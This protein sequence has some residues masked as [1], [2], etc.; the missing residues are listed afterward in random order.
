[1]SGHQSTSIALLDA[2]HNGVVLSSIAHRDT[3]RLY[4][5]QVHGGPRRAS[6]SR[7]RRTRRSGSRSPA[8]VGSV[9]ARSALMRVALPRAAGT[10][11]HEAL[12][13]RRR[14]TLERRAAADRC[15]TSCCAVQERRGRARA[16]ADRER[17]R[18]RASTPTLDALAFEARDVAIVGEVVHPVY[19]LPDR[20]RPRARARRRS[21]RCSRTRRR[22]ASARASCA[23][24][25]RARR[26]CRPPRPPTRSAH[27]AER[28]RD[29]A[30]RAAIGTPAGRAAAT[31]RV[32]LAE[33]VED[34]RRQRDALRLARPRGAGRAG[35]AGGGPAKT[36]LVFWGAGSSSPGLARALPGRVRRSRGV[37]LTRIESRPRARGLGDVHVLPR[38]R[39]ARW[40]I[41]R[42]PRRSAR[43][44]GMPRCVRVLG[45]FATG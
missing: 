14:P 38:P 36:A 7:P 34:D 39:R 6:S 18:G 31:A 1:M 11:A 13:A 30:P 26:S 12:I 3:A 42:W 9:I 22:S 43:C 4:C 8:S 29:G 35:A 32:M 17:A 2:D 15:A 20:A 25:C 41:R 5:K 16:R 27:V 37:N 40:P 24:S 45:S 33:D 19:L 44:A 23:R 28:D 21:R 10:S